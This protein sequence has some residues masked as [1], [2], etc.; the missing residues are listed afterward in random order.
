MESTDIHTPSRHASD[1]LLSV[2][3]NSPPS[4]SFGCYASN[5]WPANRLGAYQ[6][7]FVLEWP[8]RVIDSG[9]GFPL[10]PCRR[11]FAAATIWLVVTR[12][13]PS[14]GHSL[15]PDGLF[16][17]QTTRGPSAAPCG[18]HISRFTNHLLFWNCM[19]LA[20]QDPRDSVVPSLLLM[21]LKGRLVRPGKS[22]IF[23]VFSS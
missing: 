6:R 20:L 1:D 3:A 4:S 7:M 2:L 14:H 11:F 10:P 9:E 13:Y 15:V 17:S 18:S 21:M 23:S 12:R 16:T 19:H 5:S 22:V 8:N